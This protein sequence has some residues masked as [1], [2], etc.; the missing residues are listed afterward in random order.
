MGTSDKKTT[1]DK[2]IDPI[3]EQFSR[4]IMRTLDSTEFYEYFMDFVAT[5]RYE[6]QFSNRRLEK[7]VDLSWVDAIEEA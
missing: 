3:Y 1:S 2:L 7:I 4:S 6:F 5:G